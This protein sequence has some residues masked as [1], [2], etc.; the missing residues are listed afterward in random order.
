MHVLLGIFTAL[1][2][3]ASII[4]R[5][6]QGMAAAR[7]VGNTARDARLAV[8]K[9]SWQRK[10]KHSMLD[11]VA[12]PRE[13][14]A[15]MMVAVAQDDGAISA[16][17]E[18]LITAL[19]KAHFE[20]GE[21]DAKEL[22]AMGRYLSQEMGD[23]STFLRRLS[24]AVQAHC[25]RKEQSDLIAMLHAVGSADGDIDDGVEHAIMRLKDRLGV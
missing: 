24:K 22:M 3:A 13:A 17:E 9:W 5:I 15:A 19:C 12:D 21:S 10:F 18:N 4:W 6:Q 11:D 2:V 16:R 20:V 1:I 14:G 23:L 8:R 7:T 25:S